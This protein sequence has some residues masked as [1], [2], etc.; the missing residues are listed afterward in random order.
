MTGSRTRGLSAWGGGAVTG[1]LTSWESP[2]LELGAEVPLAS[3]R[4]GV[5]NSVPGGG[6]RG[7]RRGRAGD[8]CVHKVNRECGAWEVQGG[9]WPLPSACWW[10]DPATPRSPSRS[11]HSG[12]PIPKTKPST[13]P[14][15]LS[16]GCHLPG[17][18]RLA[19]WV[20]DGTPQHLPLPVVR[21]P[22]R[23]LPS[24]GDSS[25]A[26]PCSPPRH[27]AALGS[28][29]RSAVLFLPHRGR[30]VLTEVRLLPT[31]HPPLPCASS[32]PSPPPE[33]SHTA[34]PVCHACSLQ[35]PQ[36]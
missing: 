22:P 25:V 27:T 19:P 6:G 20:L 26:S 4:P 8:V 29:Q 36:P 24:P 23:T 16:T 17:L 18:L 35:D 33:R 11:L 12:G 31:P 28:A 32:W 3:A 21:A 7:S 30:P 10:G 1:A 14:G 15:A 9:G 13:R 2:T 34:G 5:R